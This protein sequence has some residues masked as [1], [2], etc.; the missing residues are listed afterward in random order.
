M[1]VAR[2][3]CV[4]A[5]RGKPSWVSALVGVGYAWLF[6]FLVYV[7]CMKRVRDGR[8]ISECHD[9][10]QSRLL[11]DGQV[12]L[13][14]VVWRDATDIGGDWV[15]AED[16]VLEPAMS[17]SVGYLIA[18]NKDS[19]SIAGLVN[20]THFAHGMTIPRKMVVEIRDLR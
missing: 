7:G 12:R 8:V 11:K 2:S 5:I 16:A 13:V 20:E 6:L 3:L 4:W 14:E 1:V 9:I 18:S 10:V 15:S 17:F 19:V